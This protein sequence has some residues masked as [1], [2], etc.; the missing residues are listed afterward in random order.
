MEILMITLFL[1]GYACIAME[2]SIKVNK[3]ASALLLCALLWTIY[4]FNADG[5]LMQ[6]PELVG[7]L[8]S[9]EDV[10]S[11]VTG[12]Q[13]IEH[14]GDV[15]ST[16][17]F[18]MGAMTIVEL[19]DVHGGFS[20][21]TN[22]ISTKDKKKLLWLLSFITFIMSAIL[23]NLTTT[24][25]MVMLLR[26]LISE[27]KERW[28]FACI[29]VIAANSGGAFSPIGDVT[30]IM[31]WVKGNIT[32]AGVI[33][34]LLVPSLI[35]ML[36]PTFI[37]SLFMKGEVV[38]EGENSTGHCHNVVQ[39]VT[40]TDQKIIFFLGVGALLFV[41]VF[42][43][44]T[45]LPPFV[46]VLFGLGVLWVYTELFYHKSKHIPEDSKAR[47]SDIIGRIDLTTI[48]FFLGILMAVA[49]LQCAGIL[50]ML[51]DFL[52]KNVGNV[53]VID[54][55]I[56]V[57]SSIVD[58]VPLVAGSMGMYSIPTE[59][60]VL[61]DPSLAVYSVDGVFWLFLAYCAGVGGSILIIGSAAGVVV[62]GLEKVPFGWYVKHISLL[63]LVGYLA[64]A[65]FFILQEE[66]ILPL[67]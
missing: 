19:I 58:N 3:A 7:K 24:I 35:S 36:V 2:H 21:I 31:L 12:V 38:S 30:T 47:I 64:G 57:L 65:L 63:A 49:A 60:Q 32:T 27:K 13:I 25:V 61:A 22:C 56:G 40:Q 42:K 11:Y 29:I 59:A 44:I 41:P 43:S 46:G 55:I 15:A 1:I 50:G 37:A 66:F 18:L 48:L 10:V 45:H 62:M 53:Y 9:H 52:E 23:D 8:S 26:K 39:Y 20:I 67:L 4:I 28:M 6:I 54:I 14:L 34:N 17:F 16:L 33:P 51:S 5:V